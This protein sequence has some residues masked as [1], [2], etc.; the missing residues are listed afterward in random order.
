MNKSLVLI[1][2]YTY[3][4]EA[5]IVKGKLESEG[6]VVYMFDNVTIDTDPLVSN[7]IGGVKLLVD[8]EN[9]EKAIEILNQI[10]KY[11]MSNN[12]TLIKCPYCREQKAQMITSLS[13]AKS[14]FAFITSLFFAVLPFYT[15]YTYKC[16]N[17]NKEFN[18]K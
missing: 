4:S 12:G 13:N 17:C 5:L 3:S 6:I 7:A 10:S 8:K 18:I 14:I 16:N 2:T 1:A 11:S 9:E 15:K